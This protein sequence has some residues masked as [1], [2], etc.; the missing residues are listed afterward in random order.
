MFTELFSNLV[1]TRNEF[2]VFDQVSFRV[3][4][5][6]KWSKFVHAVL[7]IKIENTQ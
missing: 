4:F 5:R 6:Q 7:V 2:I 1:V 3:L